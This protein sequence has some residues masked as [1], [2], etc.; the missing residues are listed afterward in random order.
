MLYWIMHIFGY[1][2]QVNLELEP[3]TEGTHQP[4]VP[5]PFCDVVP[6][7]YDTCEHLPKHHS[8]YV[9]CSNED[10]HNDSLNLPPTLSDE[11][12][13][14]MTLSGGYGE[15]SLDEAIELWNASASRFRK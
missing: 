1:R 11:E 5:C 4:I 12:Y 3:I 15:I 2:Q 9:H 7:P 8:W 10:K 13:D 14:R 6:V